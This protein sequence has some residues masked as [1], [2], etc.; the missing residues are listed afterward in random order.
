MTGPDRTFALL[1]GLS[2]ALIAAI[3]WSRRHL[4][5]A[6]A[7][8]Y[9]AGAAWPGITCL[10]LPLANDLGP[11]LASYAFILA[12]LAG[13]TA[14]VRAV[15]RQAR[16]TRSLLRACLSVG[17]SR[18]GVV[19]SVDAQLQLRDRLDIVNL[20]E[21][22]AFRYGYLRPRV[23]VSTGLIGLLPP[24]ELEAVL[25]HEREH[26]RRLDPLKV[27]VGKL[28]A[29]TGFFLPILG[30]L[31]RRFLVEKELAADRAVTVAQ[32][33]GRVWALRSSAWPTGKPRCDRRSAP[34]PVRRS[35]LASTLCWVIR[36]GEAS[37][38]DRVEWPPASSWPVWSS[39]HC[40]RRPWRPVSSPPTTISSPGVI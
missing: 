1:T 4:L 26:M 32:G 3:I 38:S 11:H 20:A 6:G 23:L 15:L 19:E 37:D 10:L 34:E 12:M 31:Y 27:A 14:G 40:W 25:L 18:S 9:A 13:A 5:L 29:S 17:S 30:A 24:P 22:I 8:A 16:S 36:C 28:L 7:P 35:M 2:V 39:Y 33:D 21:P